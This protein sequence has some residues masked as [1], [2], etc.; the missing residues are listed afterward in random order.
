MDEDMTNLNTI[1]GACFTSSDPI[2]YGQGGDL[3]FS[4]G[5]GE[6]SHHF[7]AVAIEHKGVG[8]GK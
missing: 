7:L 5:G 1:K 3:L 4:Q 6:F 8:S 2:S